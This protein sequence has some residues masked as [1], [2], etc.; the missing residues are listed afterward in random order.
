MHTC[1][2]WHVCL[3]VTRLDARVRK[4]ALVWDVACLLVCYED[5]CTFA[6]WWW[7]VCLCEEKCIFVG[8]SHNR[9]YVRKST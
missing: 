2:M 9:F 8:C 6:G 1:G 7:R 5:R 4:D 3:C